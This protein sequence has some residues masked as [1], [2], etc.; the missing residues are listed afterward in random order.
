M[1]HHSL[2]HATPL[3]YR[4]LF[5]HSFIT[6]YYITHLSYNIMLLVCRVI[7]HNSF[8]YIV[9]PPKCRTNVT[10]FICR[11]TLAFERCCKF[12]SILLTPQ[13]IS[14]TVR[15]SFHESV[16]AR[17]TCLT[18]SPTA[19]A[20]F[21]TK[22]YNSRAL[23]GDGTLELR[24]LLSC[25]QKEQYI[26]SKSQSP[27]KRRKNNSNRWCKQWTWSDS[28]ALQEMWYGSA[29]KGMQKGSASGRC[30]TGVQTGEGEWECKREM[31]YGRGRKWRVHTNANGFF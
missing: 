14:K 30:G 7:L 29:N 21:H 5:C 18:R 27:G 6:Q 11:I 28:L 3:I 1:L 16:R 2:S 17:A 8:S 31:K 12:I 25:L 9:M 19:R 4:I 23:L 15:R 26:S 10:S 22:I 24:L 20:E 13:P